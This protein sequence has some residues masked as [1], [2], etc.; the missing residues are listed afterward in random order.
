MV[1]DMVVP[2]P[3]QTVNILCEQHKINGHT[4]YVFFSQTAKKHQII[5][6][7]TANMHLK[8]LDYKDIHC[9]HGFRATAKT[10]LQEQLKCSGIIKLDST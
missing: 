4:E 7:A 1:K 6:D 10:I 5:S 3:R 9:A 8:D 2:L